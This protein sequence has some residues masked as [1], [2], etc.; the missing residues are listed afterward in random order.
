MST[1]ALLLIAIIMLAVGAT[2]GA[3]VGRKLGPHSQRS[4]ELEEQLREAE[5]R[6]S[7]YQGEVAEHFLETSRRINDLTRNYKE[8]HEYLASSAMKL[9][10]PSLGRDLQVSGQIT[11][12]ED[13]AQDDEKR[14]DEGSSPETESAAPELEPNGRQNDHQQ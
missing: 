13:Q 10:T 6:L 2:I 8:V 5:Q 9:T 11:W 4:L 12:P 7:T 3:L 14:L 1:F